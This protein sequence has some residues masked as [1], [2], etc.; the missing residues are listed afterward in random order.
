[1]P[2]ANSASN[3]PFAIGIERVAHDSVSGTSRALSGG[4]PNTKDVKSDAIIQQE[5]MAYLT[6]RS[7]AQDTLEGI[8]EWWLL[9]QKVDQATSDVKAALAQLVIEKKLSAKKG[10]D[11]RVHYRLR[12]RESKTRPKAIGNSRQKGR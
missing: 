7:T 11:G 5:I 1:M 10:A 4:E 3:L 8:V 9:E 12:E 2:A 6:V